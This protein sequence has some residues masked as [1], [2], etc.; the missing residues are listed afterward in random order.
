M[1]DK[2]QIAKIPKTVRSWLGYL[3][4]ILLV[5]K[6]IQHVVVTVCFFYN[7]FDIRSK[8]AIDYHFLMISG[9]IV[10]ALFAIAFWGTVKNKKWGI[11]LASALAMLDI[12]GEFVAQGTISITITVSIIVA[13][14]LLVLCYCEYQNFYAK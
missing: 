3:L 12:V 13:I 14:I 8:V 5:E 7:T 4:I 11:I 9:A 10:A 2:E 1:T 6:V